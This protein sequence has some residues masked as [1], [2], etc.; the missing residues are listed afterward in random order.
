MGEMNCPKCKAPMVIDEWNGWVWTCFNCDYVGREATDEE[1]D[2]QQR[3]IEMF[4]K[5]QKGKYGAN[6]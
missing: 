5:I 1:C 6:T 2:L 3:E 4:S